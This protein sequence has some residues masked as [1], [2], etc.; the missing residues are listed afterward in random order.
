MRTRPIGLKRQRVPVSAARSLTFEV[1]ASAGKTLEERPEGAKVVQFTT[2]FRGRDV[3]TKELIMIEPPD[4]IRYEWLQ[5][6]LPEV[7]EVISF[8]DNGE[9]TELVYDGDFSAGPGLIKWV[10]GW[11]SSRYSTGSS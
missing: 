3:H 5:G 4:R 8:I 1:V 10:Y 11:W 6:P 2:T 9:G 7:N